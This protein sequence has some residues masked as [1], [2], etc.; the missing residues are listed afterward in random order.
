[1]AELDVVKEQIAYSKFWLGIMVVT[2]LSLFG[3]L[4]SHAGRPTVI[5]VIGGWFAVIVTGVGILL[6]HRR[7]KGQIEKLRDL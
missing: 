3:W 7:I 1:M 6:V 5:L 4:I 2:D